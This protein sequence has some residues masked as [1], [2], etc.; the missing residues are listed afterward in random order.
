MQLANILKMAFLAAMLSAHGVASAESACARG[1]IPTLLGF[2]PWPPD[3][4]LGGLSRAYDF[5][6]TN[7]NIVSHHMDNGIPWQQALTGARLPKNLR[8]DW[9]FRLEHT[10][11]DAKILLSFSP[12]DSG[13]EALAP[14]WNDRG[15]N[16]PLPRDWARRDLDHPDVVRAY[17]AYVLQGVVAFHPDYLAIGIEANILLATAPDKWP[18]YLRL[19]EAVYAAV[20]ADYPDLPVFSTVQY[21]YLRGIADESRQNLAAQIPGVKALMQHS[22]LLALSTYRFGILHRNP[23]KAGYFDLARTFGKPVAISESGAMSKNVIVNGAILPAFASTQSDFVNMLLTNARDLKF[24]FLINWTAIDYDG[25]LAALPIDVR[26]LAKAWVY[27]GLE[28]YKGHAKP[29][30]ALWRQCLED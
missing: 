18:A 27:T 17:T 2:T 6:A 7:A 11:H 24:P 20:K 8:D 22:D 26:E 12:L 14:V 23:P 29:A 30:L 4:S 1:P 9:A 10:P 25:T 15:D 13:R 3:L 21:E 28:D 16:Q 5:I 19:N